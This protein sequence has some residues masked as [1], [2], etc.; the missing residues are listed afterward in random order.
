YDFSKSGKAERKQAYLPK[1]E[2]PQARILVVDDNE[3]NLMVVSKHLRD[4]KDRID[5]A[6]SGA[7]ALR[8]TLNIKYNV[9]FMDHLMPEMDGIECRRKIK[10]Q[11]GGRCRESAIVIL[12][13]NADEENR[14]LYARENFDGY[15]SKPVSGDALENELY[16]H[17]PKEIVHITGNRSEIAQESI[18]W[19]SGTK[20]RKSI[21]ITTESVAD[22]SPEL[23]EKYGIAVIPHKVR[24]DEGLFKDGK[25]IETLGVLK[26]MEN[27]KNNVL[28]EGPTIKEAEEFFAKQLS[29]A[30]NV[31]HIS[32]SSKIEHSGYQPA[33]EASKS[34][35]NVFVIDS[36]HV[37]SGQGLMA[38]IA[39]KMAEEGLSAEE[40]VKEMESLKKKVHTSFIV[41]NLDFLARAGQVGNGTANVV[42]SLMGRPVLR[43][44]N[45]KMGVG[46]TYFGARE[47]AWKAYINS[48]LA[49]TAKIDTSI[50]F[51]TYVGLSKR[52]TDWIRDQIE[53]YMHFDEIYFKQASPA[54]SVNC[55]PGT[56]GLLFVEK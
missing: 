49:H 19:M 14:A 23:I 31:I 13:A 40:I 47:N 51:V 26:Y 29:F 54:V 20:K 28:P 2:A 24:T 55:G 18:S 22:L 53:K 43:L 4:T 1:F 50:L 15:L 6:T 32:I 36:G 39:A 3:A 45:G 46:M 42:K 37:S 34:F 48:L 12:T 5:T 33:L 41:D 9:I 30:N 11:T 21:V 52:D 7:E 10:E 16:S 25:E 35:D 56:F 17:L 8:K 44:R 38:V 27:P